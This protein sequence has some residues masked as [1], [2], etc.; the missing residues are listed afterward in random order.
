M[1]TLFSRPLRTALACLAT[2]LGMVHAL[3]AAAQGFPNRTVRIVVPYTPGGGIDVLARLLGAKLAESWGQPVV[4]EN[5]PGAGANLGTDMVAK[6]APDGYSWVIVSNTLALAAS[7]GAKLPYDPLKDLAPAILATTAPFV[8]AINPRLGTTTVKGLLEVARTRPGGLNFASAGQ[9][10]STHLAIEL[11]KARTGMPALHVPYKGSGPALTDLVDGRVDALFATPAA[12]MPFVR[13]KKLVALAV[14]GKR[15]TDSAPGVP[16]MVEEGIANY[17]VA[18]WFGLLGPGG[19]PPEI[20]RKFHQD[21]VKVL[22]Q[23]DVVARL[24]GQ[25][26]DI[27]TLGPDEFAAFLRSEISTWGGIV[28]AA[29]VTFN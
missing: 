6:A 1:P 24:K 22:G 4:I 3:P 27:T 15:R 9:G 2:T 20:L 11:L 14:T 21:S 25:G 17:E 28:K 23:A 12:I 16:T 26:Q 18:V 7:S 5:R 8:L 10:T 19:T 13:D 29:G